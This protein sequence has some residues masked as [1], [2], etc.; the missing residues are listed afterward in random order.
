MCA[1]A[2]SG[3]EYLGTV[4]GDWDSE[5]E[6]LPEGPGLDLFESPGSLVDCPAGKQLT[7]GGAEAPDAAPHRVVVCSAPRPGPSRTV[8]SPPPRTS[9]TTGTRAPRSSARM[10]STASP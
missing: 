6:R 7:G 4:A 1:A 5:V 2:P 9:S 8:R 3:L 10:S